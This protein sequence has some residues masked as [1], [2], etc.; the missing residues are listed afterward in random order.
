MIVSR[1]EVPREGRL[2]RTRRITRKKWCA[3]IYEARGGEGKVGVERWKGWTL[4]NFFGDKFAWQVVCSPTH[5]YSP[6]ILPRILRSIGIISPSIRRSLGWRAYHPYAPSNEHHEWLKKRDWP[7]VKGA[8][9]TYDCNV[10]LL[11]K[12]Y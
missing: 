10:D 11:E 7:A 4:A 3:G 12:T 8:L 9:F 6:R 1:D 2:R 5:T